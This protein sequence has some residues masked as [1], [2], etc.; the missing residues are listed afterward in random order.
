MYNKYCSETYQLKMLIYIKFSKLIYEMPSAFIR[1]IK[2]GH[3]F[4]VKIMLLKVQFL[5]IN[6]V[7]IKH[8]F[9][10]YIFISF[11]L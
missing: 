9:I 11:N 2:K 7:R 8:R 5:N 1:F 10:S 4:A 6:I 3:S